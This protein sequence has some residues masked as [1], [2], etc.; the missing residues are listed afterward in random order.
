MEYNELLSYLTNQ[1]DL[2]EQDSAKYIAMVDS[3][4]NSQVFSDRDITTTT[5]TQNPGTVDDAV[6][7]YP[8]PDLWRKARRVTIDGVQGEYVSPRQFLA[9]MDGGCLDA[10]TIIGRDL[11]TA[12]GATVEVEYYRMFDTMNGLT[13]SWVLQHYPGVYVAGCDYEAAMYLYEDQRVQMFKA[14]YEEEFARLLDT[15]SGEDSGVGASLVV[16]AI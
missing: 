2:H 13:P 3:R 15:V 5:L 7:K 14:R 6:G 4:L 8:I 11:R 12:S 1:F 9:T 16:R 10:Y